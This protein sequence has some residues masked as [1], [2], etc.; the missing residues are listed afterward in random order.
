MRRKSSRHR[1]TALPSA[2]AT[3]PTPK[4]SGAE[5]TRW[6]VFRRGDPLIDP[7]TKETLGY[8]ATYLG[9]AELVKRG[10]ISTIAITKATQEIYRGDKLLPMPKDEPVFA[11]VP[12]APQAA[13]QG[14]V[15]STYGGFGR[16]GPF[17]SLH[18]PAALVTASKSGT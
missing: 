6:Q 10:N 11:Y 13:V 14:R 1:K 16:P 18:S 12:H 15:V 4:K 8:V 17:Q 7:E 3:R 9:E 2:A 5:D